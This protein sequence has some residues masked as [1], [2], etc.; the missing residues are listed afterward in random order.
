MTELSEAARE[1]DFKKLSVGADAELIQL[2]RCH[3][4]SLFLAKH[5]FCSIHADFE[6]SRSC[7]S[8]WINS[9]V[10]VL[11]IWHS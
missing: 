11:C 7:V 5:C 9:A 10:G 2:P 4:P 1:Y 8:S 6:V 3:R